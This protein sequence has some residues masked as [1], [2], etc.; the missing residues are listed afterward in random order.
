MPT[1]YLL[2]KSCG[3]FIYKAMSLLFEIVH[4]ICLYQ[5]VS[6]RT[7]RNEPV[8]LR[9]RGK[10]CFIGWSHFPSLLRTPPLYIHVYTIFLHMLNPPFFF[11]TW[12][13]SSSKERQETVPHRLGFSFPSAEATLKVLQRLQDV[14]CNP[15][16]NHSMNT[17]LMH[18]PSLSLSHFF[19]NLLNP[20]EPSFK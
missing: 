4:S 20:L 7:H 6:S 2:V 1:D 17:P 9:V 8:H 16:G 11:T 14:P 15:L 10:F 13:Q 18:V 3:N 12:D 5:G 19:G